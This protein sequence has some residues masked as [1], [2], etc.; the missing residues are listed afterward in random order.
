MSYDGAED[1]DAKQAAYYGSPERAAVDPE[2]DPAQFIA[3]TER[4]FIGPA[5]GVVILESRWYEQDH[6]RLYSDGLAS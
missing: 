4:W 3:K 2:L 1:W 5:R 6:C